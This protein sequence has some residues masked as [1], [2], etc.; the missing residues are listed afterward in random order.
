MV[1]H[2]TTQEFDV[3]VV[4]RDGNFRFSCIWMPR[5]KSFDGKSCV[6]TM[7]SDSGPVDADAFA[8]HSA[9]PGHLPLGELVDGGGEL[10][11]HLLVGQFSDDVLG[12]EFVFESVVYEVFRSYPLGLRNAFRIV[13]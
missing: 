4:R 1:F 13:E 10:C 2:A 6:V 5:R 9:E 8:L 7:R 12:D 11:A 3:K